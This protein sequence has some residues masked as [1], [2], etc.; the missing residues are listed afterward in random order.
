MEICL[1]FSKQTNLLT[2]IDL[3]MKAQGII[4]GTLLTLFLAMVAVQLFIQGQYGIS[5]VFGVMLALCVA[6]V[7][8]EIN[9]YKEDK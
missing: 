8:C 3:T 7:K 2:K 6:M 4:I 5:A 1:K 9:E